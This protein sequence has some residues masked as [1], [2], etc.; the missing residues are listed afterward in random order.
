M[1]VSL[2]DAMSD[3]RS[4]GEIIQKGVNFPHLDVAPATTD[5]VGAEIELVGRDQRESV[6][7]RI[8]GEVRDSY[9]YVLID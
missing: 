5:L 6:M 8:L 1:S 3:G 7:R 2:Y 9:D 4:L